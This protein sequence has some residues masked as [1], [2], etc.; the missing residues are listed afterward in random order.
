MLCSGCMTQVTDELAKQHHTY[1]I[2]LCV[3]LL[4]CADCSRTLCLLQGR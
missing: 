4:H 3:Q 2:I 1:S